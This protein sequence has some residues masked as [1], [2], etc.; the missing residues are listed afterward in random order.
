ML[1]HALVVTFLKYTQR[2]VKVTHIICTSKKSR[3]AVAIS[4]GKN[5]PRNCN[6]KRIPVLYK[7][8]DAVQKLHFACFL[9]ANSGLD[10]K[11]MHFSNFRLQCTRH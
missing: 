11:S 3:Y 5:Q 2:P 6:Q 4:Y 10:G 1:C 7:L 9:F 8:S